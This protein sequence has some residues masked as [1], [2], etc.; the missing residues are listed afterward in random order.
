MGTSRY[1]AFI[2]YSHA[3]QAVARWLH[4]AIETYRLPK[5]LI[6]TDSPFGPVPR[7]LPPVFRD[8]DELPASGDLGS[9]LRGALSES[10]FQIVLCS[11]RAAQSKWVNEEIL[12][13]KR[14]HG[15]N[16]TLALITG[17]EPYAGGDE[18]CF[19]PALRFKLAPD[20]SLSDT[21][22]EP[23]AADI[24]PG[25]DGRRLALLKLV[26]G[27]TGLKLDALARRDAARRQRRLVYLTAASLA[28][29]VLTI[30]LAIY[31]ESQRRVAEHQRRLA[32]KSLQFLI[33][34]FAIANP[35]TENPRTITALTILDRVSK[36]AGSE[37][38][39]E[40]AVSARLLQ[41]TGE[42]YL[43]LGL[44][45]E[46]ERDL[47]AS[48]AL[49]PAKS[50]GRARTLIRL[51]ILAY[52]RGDAKSSAGFIDA[53]QQSYDENA[54]YAPALDAWILE[55]RGMVSMLSG[56]YLT[57][58]EQ[59]DQAATS[60]SKLSGDYRQE[61]GRAWL[62]QGRALVLAKKFAPANVLFAKGAEL[63]TAKFGANHV[64]TANAIQNQASGYFEAGRFPE[65]ERSAARA[66]GIYQ[67]VLE[68][69]HP[70]IAASQLLLGR[71]RTSQ[72]DFAEAIVS[73][74]KA[75]GIYERIYGPRNVA[76][77][78]VDF[79]AAEAEAK[80]KD[81]DAALRLLAQTK[82]I[83]D[84]SYGPD[85]PDQVELLIAR[86]K[87]LRGAG[88]LDEARRDCTAGLALQTKLDPHDPE[89]GAT[90]Q[91]C[92]AMG[93]AKSGN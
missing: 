33:D 15:E 7:R 31:A 93:A 86:A 84:A 14:V 1:A 47:R 5:A 2:S 35:A 76:V 60:Y 81:T 18:E 92:A 23:I 3:D 87:V 69:D 12:S 67:R 17:G 72:G 6:G 80:R 38:K 65:A 75:R 28:V 62:T 20:G 27:I 39:D 48:L 77:G 61:L 13:F 9:E 49:E 44:P 55:R 63:Y 30:G 56:H 59:L 11:P 85:D 53:A 71:I 42:I 45:K 58:A 19:P 78:D 40:P 4:R 83:Y 16:R 50:E 74:D 79:Y 43:N 57:A 46:S 91:A 90:R 52:R 29:A 37:L 41:T 51:A 26:A 82:A 8:R 89:L 34:T 64:L 70:T 21:P 36:R 73:F 24:R 66:I 22:A 25:K 32:D 54:A 88:R 10:R 68:G